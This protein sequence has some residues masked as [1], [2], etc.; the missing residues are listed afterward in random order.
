MLHEKAGEYEEM[1]KYTS[2]MMQPERTNAFP[3]YC[4]FI[5]TSHYYDSPTGRVQELHRYAID[6]CNQMAMPTPFI[7][8]KHLDRNLFIVD[9]FYNNPNEVRN[10]AMNQVEYKS[11]LRWYKGLR[12][13][14]CYRSDD[15]RRAFENI[16]GENINNWEQGFNG[17]FQITTAEDPQV[18]HYDQQKWAAMIYLTPNAPLESGTRTHI[19]KIT[20]LT[21][22]DQDGV[23]MSFA[24]GFYDSTKFHIADSAA[25][26]YN[27]LVI[28]DARMIH[29]AGAYFGNSKETG[30][31]THLF[32]F[33]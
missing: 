30:R 12:S 17:C 15:I 33:D 3:Q 7:I 6:K 18:Y 8:N 29:S 31:L 11:D 4:N 22:S 2:K 5:D 9:N 21:H 10:F 1:L 32:F 19:S 23:D 20:G 25:N 26:I 27:R 28:M 16:I 14:V 24:S 13:T